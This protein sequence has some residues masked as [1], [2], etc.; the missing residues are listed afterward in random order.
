MRN[1]WFKVYLDRH[2]NILAGSVTAGGEEGGAAAGAS[3]AR[4]GWKNKQQAQP[5]Q[6]FY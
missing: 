6:S 3:L 1:L 2:G 4:L 5:G